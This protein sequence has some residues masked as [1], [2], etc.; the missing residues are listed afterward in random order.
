[1]S[2]DADNIYKEVHC[3]VIQEKEYWLQLFVTLCV[4]LAAEL[5]KYTR[6]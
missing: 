3:V 6:L 2:F 1:M 4:C 5:T